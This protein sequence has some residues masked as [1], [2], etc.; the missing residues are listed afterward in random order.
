MEKQRK[1]IRPDRISDNFIELIGKEW[2]LVAAGDREKMNMMT[3]SWGGVGFLW[4]RPVVF[5]F[6]RPERYTLAFV[7]AKKW[8]T[9][10]FFGGEYREAYTLC[11]SRS[12]REIDKVAATGLTPFFTAEGNP[13]FEEARLTLEC[14]TLAVSEMKEDDFLDPAVYERW[15]NAT[16][17]NPHRVY[18]AEIVHAWERTA[19]PPEESGAYSNEK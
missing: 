15:Y 12:G 6:I 4:N 3:A 16:Q 1:E 9:L 17:G 19:C 5:V 2:M 18:V 10:S 8:F 7:E 13:G 11:G 14:K